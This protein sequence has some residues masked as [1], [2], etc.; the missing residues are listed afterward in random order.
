MTSNINNTSDS[1][2]KKKYISVF[3]FG[4]D[5]AFSLLTASGGF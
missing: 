4:R 3:F 1:T 5:F 2:H